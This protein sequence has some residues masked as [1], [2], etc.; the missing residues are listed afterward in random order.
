MGDF[1]TGERA[2]QRKLW[3]CYPHR[4]T[5]TLVVHGNV[6]IRGHLLCEQRRTQLKTLLLFSN[7]VLYRYNKCFKLLVVSTPLCTKLRLTDSTK[8]RY[9][10]G[11]KLIFFCGEQVDDHLHGHLSLSL[12]H[13]FPSS[14]LHIN[15]Y[16]YLIFFWFLFLLN[17]HIISRDLVTNDSAHSSGHRLWHQSPHCTMSCCAELPELV[18]KAL[19]Q[20][21]S[22]ARL[23]NSSEQAFMDLLYCC[24]GSE[25]VSLYVT[26]LW[27]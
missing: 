8:F 18:W 26:V 10:T 13:S 6:F 27:E 11:Q 24:Q 21:E 2:K 12:S 25:L 1:C 20:C 3:Q 9:A 14:F 15:I 16:I 4:E 5:H 7:L 23:I 22:A 17:T 19:A